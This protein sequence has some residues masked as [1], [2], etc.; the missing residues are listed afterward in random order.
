V[1]PLDVDLDDYQRWL[2]EVSRARARGAEPPL[3]PTPEAAPAAAAPK[4]APAQTP[5]SVSASPAATG[6]S[7]RDERKQLAQARA[8]RASRTRPMRIELAQIDTRLE[9]LAAERAEIEAALNSGALA[10]AQIAD[11][12]R[13]LNHVAAE[14][15]RLEERWLE[16]QTAI[17]A[18]EG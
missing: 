16:L 1:E 13:R 7:R 15:Q 18:G 5:A 14:V 4:A 9:K 17:E 3:R 2:L 11:H 10:S 12:G 8:E 6:G